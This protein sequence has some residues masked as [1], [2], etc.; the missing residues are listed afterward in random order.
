V[1]LVTILIDNYNY[2][3]YLGQAVDSA[4]AQTHP[5]VEVLVV[6]DGSTDGSREI[7]AGYGERIRTILQANAGQAAAMNRGLAEARGEILLTLDSDDTLEPDTA[8][9][10]AAVFADDPAC[11]RIQYRL[12]TVDADGRATGATM[13]PRRVPLQDGDLRPLLLR[14]RGFRTAPTSGNAWST[15]ALRRLPAVPEDSYRQHVDRWWSDLIAL[16]G[17]SRVLPG[18]AGTYRVHAVSHS[19][20]ERR[21]LNYFTDRLA[22]RRVLHEAARQVAQEAGLGELPERPEQMQDAALCSWRLAAY[23][24]GLPLERRE[25]PALLLSGVRDNLRQPDKPWRARLAHTGWFLALATTPRGAR[26]G[27]MIAR[28]YARED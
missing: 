18:T 3:A 10:V 25:L 23:K 21:E 22:R 19:T 28:R 27:R 20:V 6:D 16:L 12:A 17:T 13:P 4:L 9:R 14:A 15:A 1:P 7:L 11:V 26:A 5:R 24:L 8:A 2:A